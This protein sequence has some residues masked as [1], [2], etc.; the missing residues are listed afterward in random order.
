MIASTPGI[1]NQGAV[2]SAL[3]FWASCIKVPQLT[4]GGCKPKPR[5]LNGYET[6]I[7]E[8]IKEKQKDDEIIQ[9]P[10]IPESRAELKGESV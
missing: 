4:T 8:L 2:E 7:D 6:L 10:E 3:M 1:S 5:K 9:I